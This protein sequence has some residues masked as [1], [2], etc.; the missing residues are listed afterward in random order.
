M[1]KKYC[2]SRWI[3][4]SETEYGDFNSKEEGPYFGVVLKDNINLYNFG[5]FNSKHQFDG[6]ICSAYHSWFD[7]AEY[8]N[9]EL[10][11]PT[12]RAHNNP[13]IS[14]TIGEIKKG[15]AR[16]IWI[17]F[18]T[19]NFDY[20]K[21]NELGEI[22]G[23]LIHYEGKDGSIC[24]KKYEAGKIISTIDLPKK[25]PL[26]SKILS[27]A[28]AFIPTRTDFGVFR[29]TS[30]NTQTYCENS[31]GDAVG[32]GVTTVEKDFYS[33]STFANGAR[34]GYQ[35][36]RDNNVSRLLYGVNNDFTGPII[37]LRDDGIF[38]T[39]DNK[40]DDGNVVHSAIIMILDDELYLFDSNTG[41][42]EKNDPSI[43]LVDFDEISFDLKGD[44]NY[45]DFYSADDLF[46][47]KTIEKEKVEVKQPEADVNDPEYKIMSLIGQ[48]DVK[49]EFKR[50]RA[51]IQKNDASKIYKNMVFSGEDGVGKSTVAKLI[52]DVLYKYH[53]ISSKFYSERN[54]KEIFNNI[55]GGTA[56]NLDNLFKNGRGGV[57]LIDDIH[58]LDA[59]NSSEVS[60]GLWALAKIMEENPE[61]VFILCDNKYNMN[62][63]M[64]NNLTLFQRLIRFHMNFV[65]FTKEELGQILDIKLK[66]K[67][68]SIHPDAKD[69]LLEVIFLSKAYGNNINATAAIAILDEI[70]VIQN[71]RTEF[72]DDK[73]ITKDDVDVYVIENDIEFIDQKTGFQS[74][75]RK[76]L[77]ELIGLENIKETVDD[78]I[79]YFSINRG[80]KVDFHMSF[81]G[82]PGTGKT[83]VAR[84]IGK[85]LRQEG[86]L[87]TSKFL[88]VTRKDL[89]G[90]YIGQTAILTRNIIDKAMGGVLYIDEA[91]SLAYGSERGGG[92]KDY[93]QECISELLKAMEDRRGE[94]CVIMAGYTKEMER[95]FELNPG[96]KSR[97]KFHLEFPDYSD[98]ELGKIARLFLKRENAIMSDENIHLLVKL[99]SI[100]RNFPNFA[101]VR[102]L[103]EA[104]SKVQIKH[105]RKI[106]E[107]PDNPSNNEL[108]KDDILNAFSKEEM[109]LLDKFEKDTDKPSKYN[110]QK[111]K[112]LY[113]GYVPQPLEQNKDYLTEAVLALKMSDGKNG[114]GTGFIISK[115]GYFLTCAHC[116]DGARKI[117]ARR[118]ISHHGRHVDIH[119]DSTVISLDK[120]ADVA[121]CKIIADEKEEF[122]YLVLDDGVKEIEKLTHVHLLG[123]PF[124]VTRFDELS[125]NEG[126]VMSYQK[127][128]QWMEDQINLDIQAK[129]GNSG[130]PLIDSNTSKVIGVFCGSA[131][132][133]GQSITE[134]INYA[135]PIKYVWNMLDKEY[136]ENNEL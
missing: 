4:L 35:F 13:S 135:R 71:V 3:K 54:A 57:I 110:P 94:F 40:D 118:R 81:S 7:F 98:E 15:N 46:K 72:V 114:E 33:L 130:S 18:T 5:R 92:G 131:I 2:T 30:S 106:R 107:N 6:L 8:S 96:F 21:I 61:T 125:I 41:T 115:D 22:V 68:Y 42:I 24:F 136:K 113:E 104:I 47:E 74:D 129:G 82:N 123:Y 134:E 83:E 52:C 51:Y 121:L 12:I 64:E 112:E 55:T 29:L 14:V 65:D 124:G 128:N 9:G 133:Y 60:E 43:K 36:A 49:K 102:T 78:L 50:I 127:A 95:L 111:L 26:K 119:Y 48:E 11:S 132:S 59:L 85:L 122:E 56:E 27:N 86:I 39:A 80:K 87:P 32:I 69:K 84:I 99:V 23:V 20:Y 19:S 91:Y 117:I 77:D 109:E 10:I 120:K 63:I 97:V 37:E 53:A 58:Y 89:I 116:V 16:R 67:G 73:T 76:K 126:K 75:A 1:D 62:Q 70:I 100:Q 28:F 34:D 45:T 101:N 105:A 66:E 90:Q 108:T 25:F 17:D 93:G 79:A 88:E 31:N 38:I 103:R 44:N